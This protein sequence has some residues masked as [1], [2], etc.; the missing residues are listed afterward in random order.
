MS[1]I[2]RETSRKKAP[3]RVILDTKT[4]R[5]GNR[6]FRVEAETKAG[7]V[8]VL[9]AASYAQALAVANE[10]AAQYG[11]RFLNRYAQGCLS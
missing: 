6:I 2:Y 8:T 4:D 10:L 3:G 1:D 5:A 7:L 11:A 9:E